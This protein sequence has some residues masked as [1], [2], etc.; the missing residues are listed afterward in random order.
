MTDDPQEAGV[1]C[2]WKKFRKMDSLARMVAPTAR[3]SFDYSGIEV[4]DGE[5]TWGGLVLAGGVFYQ[6]PKAM[7]IFRAP[8]A[9]ELTGEMYVKYATKVGYSSLLYD[10][11]GHRFCFYHNTN[12]NSTLDHKDFSETK[13]NP[14]QYKIFP[15][16]FRDNN[17]TVVDPNALPEDQKVIYVGAGYQFDPTYQ[18]ASYAYGISV[19]GTDSCFV[20]EFNMDGMVSTGDGHPAFSGYYRLNRPQGL[21][22]NSCFASTK[23]YSGILFY[24]SGNTVYRLDFKQSG[25]KVLPVYTHTGGRAVKMK[26]A[27]KTQINSNLD[28]TAY[29][30]DPNK[31]LGVSFDMGNGVY[32]FVVLNLSE[33]GTI[34]S[35]SESYPAQQVYSG[36]GEIKDFLFL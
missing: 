6:T 33:M 12:R 30:F 5:A 20:Y 28:Y 25:G 16:P 14:S 11:G 7:K 10:A 22:E 24:A 29:E 15:V 1:Y 13:N 23:S 19:M 35:D 36:F 2:Q 18:R 9:D 31:S 34:G 3:G 32:D 26:F 4:I 21:D 27:K 17:V 8:V